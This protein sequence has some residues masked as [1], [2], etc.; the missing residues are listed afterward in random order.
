[1]FSLQRQSALRAPGNN[2]AAV[3]GQRVQLA[4]DGQLLIGKRH[5]VRG[6]GDNASRVPVQDAQQLGYRLEI[7]DGSRM[8]FAGRRQDTA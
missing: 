1:M 8:G 3:P 5:Y 4:Q 6:A 2:I 7:D